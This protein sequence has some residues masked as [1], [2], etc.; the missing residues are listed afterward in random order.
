MHTARMLKFRWI[1]V[2]IVLLTTVFQRANAQIRSEADVISRIAR[3]WN[4]REEV[5]VQGGRADLVTAT[6]A[7][8]VE[9]ASKWKNSIGQSLW[10]GL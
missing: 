9:R 6:H 2:W 8:E 4:C 5:S 1:L 3:H 7:F 10:Y